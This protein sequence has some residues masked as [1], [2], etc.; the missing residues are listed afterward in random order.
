MHL[1]ATNFYGGPEKQIVEHLKLLKKHLSYTGILGTFL[2]G[3][4]HNEILGR[5]QEA[6]IK[7]YG[8]PMSGPMDFRA[9]FEL[10]R[11]VRREEIDLLCAHHYKSV[12]LGWLAA[13]K[14]GIP[15]LNYSR[16]F[17]AENRKIAFYEWLERRFVRQMDGIISVSEGQKRRLESLG[18]NH[19]NHWVVHNGV[20]LPQNGAAENVDLRQG[21]FRKFDIP[22]K[23]LVSVSVG[24][25][26]PEKGHK[27]LLEA[28]ALTNFRENNTYYLFCGDGPCRP[29]L[30]AQAQRLDITDYCRFAGFRRDMT[31][32][33]RGIDFLVLP[34]LTEGLPNAVLEAFSF[35]KPVIATRVGGVPEVVTD[36]KSGFIVPKAEPPALAEAIEKMIGSQGLREEMGQFGK[37]RVKTCFSFEQQTR[38]LCRI[39]NIYLQKQKTE[40][41]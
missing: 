36:G 29:A 23:G 6:G 1:I 40:I 34:S 38:E 14:T 24:R 27:Y 12:V 41:S 5:A 30:E 13:R 22:E 10:I 35:R 32:I 28:I 15:V 2:E 7:S 17:T 3:N 31:D 11:I 18:I 9:L 37:Y 20:N 19:P 8:I 39:Y 33:Y 25:L 4:H 21:F 26:S 16:G